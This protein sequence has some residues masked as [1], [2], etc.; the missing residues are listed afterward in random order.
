MYCLPFHMEVEKSEAESW[1]C[2]PISQLYLVHKYCYYPSVWLYLIP[3]QPC[4]VFHGFFEKY[5]KLQEENERCNA[6]NPL[7]PVSPPSP[8]SSPPFP[9][10]SPLPHSN[11]TEIYH[12]VWGHA[13]LR[14][15]RSRN[16][17]LRKA[18]KTNVESQKIPKMYVN[19]FLFLFTLFLL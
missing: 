15:A 14:S 6:I 4:E 12:C 11:L 19:L 16:A 18:K 9:L 7:P 13:M 1:F 8:L 10:L 3:L 5:K 17:T 2:C